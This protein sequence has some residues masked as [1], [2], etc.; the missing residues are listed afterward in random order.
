M[1]LS[2]YQLT[3]SHKMCLLIIQRHPNHR[4]FSSAWKKKITEI[5]FKKCVFFKLEF[6]LN[7]CI[8]S[9]SSIFIYPRRLNYINLFYVI[10]F[11]LAFVHVPAVFLSQQSNPICNKCIKIAL[12]LK[13]IPFASHINMNDYRCIK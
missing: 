4:R 3:N 8:Y 2:V 9:L 11:P 10:L 1:V 12:H 7:F 13:S 5:V 6:S